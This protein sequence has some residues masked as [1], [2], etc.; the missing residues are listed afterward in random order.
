MIGFL[1]QGSCTYVS[2]T[3]TD[4]CRYEFVCM[5]VWCACVGGYVMGP[6]DAAPHMTPHAGL[7][8]AQVPPSV[9]T[10]GLWGIGKH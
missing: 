8:Q 10:S 5:Y 3:Y 4:V 1:Y 7:N 9:S 6:L 2:I